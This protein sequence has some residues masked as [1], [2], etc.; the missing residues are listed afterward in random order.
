MY[1]NNGPSPNCVT[2]TY[3]GKILK[4][5]WGGQAPRKNSGGSNPMRPPVPPLMLIFIFTKFFYG[6]QCKNI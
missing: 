6:T 4:E 2:Q 1:F 3:L 5:K